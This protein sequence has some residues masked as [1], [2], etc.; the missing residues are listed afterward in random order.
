[1]LTLAEELKTG[2]I[3]AILRMEEGELGMAMFEGR[4]ALPNAEPPTDELRVLEQR[5]IAVLLDARGNEIRAG[6]DAL[7]FLAQIA[8]QMPLFKRLMDICS[9]DELNE[10]CSEYPG[11]YRFANTLESI[12]ANIQSGAIRVPR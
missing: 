4:L 3:D 8:P 9:E 5:A 12:A 1:M 7:E 11:L 2:T 6:V 10:L